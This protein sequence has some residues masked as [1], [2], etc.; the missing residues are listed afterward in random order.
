MP[1]SSSGPPWSYKDEPFLP[2][3]FLGLLLVFFFFCHPSPLG[4]DFVTPGVRFGSTFPMVTTANPK[5]ITA[6]CSVGAM[7]ICICSDVACVGSTHVSTFLGSCCLSRYLSLSEK[8]NATDSCYS[9]AYTYPT[10]TGYLSVSDK[11]SAGPEICCRQVHLSHSVARQSCCKLD[12]HAGVGL[13]TTGILIDFNHHI[14]GILG[15]SVPQPYMWIRIQYRCGALSCLEPSCGSQSFNPCS[16]TH[17]VHVGGLGSC[18]WEHY[19]PLCLDSCAE[20]LRMRTSPRELGISLPMQQAIV[21][22]DIGHD[23]LLDW[24]S[25]AICARQQLCDFTCLTPNGCIQDSLAYLDEPSNIP[26][27]LTR[28]GI[29]EH[30]LRF[31]PSWSDDSKDDAAG[32]VHDVFDAAVFA[33]ASLL[34]FSTF[35][36]GRA[37]FCF[38]FGLLAQLRWILRDG[39]IWHILAACCQKN[40]PRSYDLQLAAYMQECSLIVPIGLFGGLVL[41]HA[42]GRCSNHSISRSRFSLQVTSLHPCCLV[43]P[44]VTAMMLLALMA[45][46]TGT[47]AALTALPSHVLP[48]GSAVLRGGPASAFTS[49]HVLLRPTPHEHLLSDVTAPGA[50]ASIGDTIS[51]IGSSQQVPLLS[52]SECCPTAAYCISPL[53]LGVFLAVGHLLCCL[54]GKGCSRI[55]VPAAAITFSVGCL[56]FLV[57]IGTSS[58][59][60]AATAHCLRSSMTFP[61]TWYLLAS[62]RCATEY[63]GKL[64]HALLNCCR[65]ALCILSAACLFCSTTSPTGCLPSCL[66]GSGA[67]YSAALHVVGQNHL[68]LNASYLAFALLLMGQALLVLNVFSGG[69]ALLQGLSQIRDCLAAFIGNLDCSHNLAFLPGTL[70]Q[71]I[72][73]LSVFSI[74]FNLVC[75]RGCLFSGLQEPGARQTS[76]AIVSRRSS[77]ANPLVS[78]WDSSDMPLLCSLV[79]FTLCLLRVAGPIPEKSLS[80]GLQSS[81]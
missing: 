40:V 28:K 49:I 66:R 4:N 53:M 36:L 23:L 43:P 39:K 68:T 57:G 6:L 30:V 73:T 41:L 15:V 78:A 58:V 50:E 42:L 17:D 71:T 69:V 1:S 70:F 76:H 22:G 24:C 46:A 29:A 35:Q 8:E 45:T 63:K 5:P 27:Q 13:P 44:V 74:F 81:E 60:A 37:K 12:Y 72:P 79:A 52:T 32:L 18:N 19:S 54:G 55:L 20:F 64:A 26:Y 65:G 75:F 31:L 47:A 56:S 33:S 3:S 38:G 2:V 11:T 34:L 80:E 16:S 14:H 62:R 59:F 51:C 10:S 21:W 61:C 7:G 25:A 48:Y 67:G 9:I 77:S